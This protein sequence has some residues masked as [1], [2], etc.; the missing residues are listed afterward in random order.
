MTIDKNKMD[1][2]NDALGKI[3]KEYGKGSVMKLGETTSLEIDA[4]STGS[5]GLDIASGIGGLPRGRIIEV[6]GPESSGKTTVALHCIAEAQKKDGIA[7]FIDAC[8]R[9]GIR[10]SSWG[11][12]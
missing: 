3:E 9:S 8:T 7:A 11:R 10:K 5:I 2:L 1:A 4:I 12:R 6:Y